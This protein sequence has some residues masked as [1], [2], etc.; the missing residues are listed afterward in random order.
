[1]ATEQRA[2]PMAC[3]SLLCGETTCPADCPNLPALQAFNAWR[4]RANARQ[5]DPIWAPTI[6]QAVVI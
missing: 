1:M 6:W 3:R 2:Y 4:E 5:V